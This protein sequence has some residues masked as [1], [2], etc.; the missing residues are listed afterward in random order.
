M[1]GLKAIASNNKLLPQAMNGAKVL[2]KDF[3]QDS[4]DD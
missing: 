1:N 2:L 4:T 3:Q